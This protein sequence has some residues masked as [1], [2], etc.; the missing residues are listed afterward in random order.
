MHQLH[1]GVN[2]PISYQLTNAENIIININKHSCIIATENEQNMA[3]LTSAI[4]SV[5]D[6]ELSDYARV[7][8]SYTTNYNG[9]FLEQGG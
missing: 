3:L 5:F 2:S 9:V 6:K 4:K 7:V 8:T 1:N